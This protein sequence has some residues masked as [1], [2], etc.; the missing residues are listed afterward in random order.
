MLSLVFLAVIS[1]ATE[2]DTKYI[3]RVS[4]PSLDQTLK[5]TPP[6][7]QKGK[8]KLTCRVPMMR[9]KASRAALND[10]GAGMTYSL[11]TND[12]LH[13]CE[14]RGGQIIRVPQTDPEY[15][16]LKKSALPKSD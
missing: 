14:T 2:I 11:S 15:T 7:E 6:P 16:E 8:Y 12:D 3:P 10:A 5:A 9:S 13:D 1:W 4:P